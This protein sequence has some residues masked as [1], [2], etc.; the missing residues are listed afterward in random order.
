MTMTAII[1]GGNNNKGILSS[2]L[3]NALPCRLHIG[4]KSVEWFSE[5]ELS[6]N[7]RNSIVVF[8]YRISSI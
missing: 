7:L 3:V 5:F 2:K 1:D 6:H 8:E 4:T